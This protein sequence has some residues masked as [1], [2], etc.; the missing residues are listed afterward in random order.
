MV[1]CLVDVQNIRVEFHL[2]GGEFA[3]DVEVA[4]LQGFSQFLA[5]RGLDLLADHEERAVSNDQILCSFCVF[6][7]GF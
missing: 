1:K 4:L 2:L 3:Y 5:A 7:G 6:R